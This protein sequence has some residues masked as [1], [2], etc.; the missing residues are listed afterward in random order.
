VQEQAFNQ[1]GVLRWP[2]H[3]ALELVGSFHWQFDEVADVLDSGLRQLAVSV[4]KEVDRQQ[5]TSVD[6]L[7]VDDTELW[8][9]VSVLLDLN[10]L[11]LERHLRGQ[12]VV[13]RH[14]LQILNS[15]WRLESVLEGIQDVSD[16]NIEGLSKLSQ[17]SD[18]RILILSAHTNS[19]TKLSVEEVNQDNLFMWVVE[20][21][22]LTEAILSFQVVK[23]RLN[24]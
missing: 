16:S 18:V 6:E 23:G 9:F 24:L 13:S 11:V 21:V 3:C 15:S 14:V 22:G 7:F 2:H 12:P 19:A 5:G 4:F 20:D 17:Q 10:D 8:M 1:V